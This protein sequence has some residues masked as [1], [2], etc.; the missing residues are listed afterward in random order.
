MTDAESTYYDRCLLRLATA[1]YEYCG[2]SVT[3]DR[4]CC[5]VVVLVPSALAITATVL[6]LSV[7]TVVSMG[8]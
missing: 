1:V 4:G 8:H 3:S 6:V 7:P 2:A 5:W